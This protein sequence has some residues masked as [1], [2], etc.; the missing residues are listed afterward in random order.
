[1]QMTKAQCETYERIQPKSQKFDKTDLAKYINSADLKPY[2]VAW[3][4]E[5]NST[6]FYEEM[7]KQWEKNS[8]IFNEAY[9]RDLIAKAIIYTEIRKTIMKLDW[10]QENKGYLPQL[11]TYTFSKLIYEINQ[12]GKH[13][14]YKHIWDKQSIPDFVLDDAAAI[15]RLALILFM[16][17]PAPTAI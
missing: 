17:R 2:F 8:A 14:N 13:M 1:M 10:Y 7:D 3:G 15:A 11:V 6:K 4:K 9:Y 12:L 16:I 5:V